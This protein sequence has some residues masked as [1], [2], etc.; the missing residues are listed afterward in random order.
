MDSIPYSEI[1]AHF[2][3]TI[4]WLEVREE[5]VY[6]SRRGEPAAVLMSVAE[7][8]RLT[9]GEN[10]AGEALAAW[11]QRHADYLASPE[12]EED[13]FANLRDP[14]PDGGRP[15]LDF[16]PGEETPEEPE[17]SRPEGGA[18]KAG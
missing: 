5:A 8:R 12:A 16:G 6:I 4:K 11:R 10:S 1:R 15:A 18:A 17:L 14:S 9:G 13:P 3:E 2:A 7:Y